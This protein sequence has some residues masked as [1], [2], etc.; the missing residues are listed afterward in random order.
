M[1]HDKEILIYPFPAKGW[2]EAELKDGKVSSIYCYTDIS[3]IFMTRLIHEL[4]SRLCDYEDCHI[5]GYVSLK[6]DGSFIATA[7]KPRSSEIGQTV[8]EF[9]ELEELGFD[10]PEYVMEDGMTWEYVKGMEW[11]EFVT[12]IAGEKHY[13]TTNPSQQFTSKVKDILYTMQSGKVDGLVPVIRLEEPQIIG[14]RAKIDKINA[15]YLYKLLESDSYR[16]KSMVNYTYDKT[17]GIV[18][19]PKRGI[20]DEF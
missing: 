15:I 5:E 7:L 8:D 19:I 6:D 11:T 10:I 18:L 4:E 16:H 14:S 12:E 9:S 20:K 3:M 17:N 13:L 1:N 2:V